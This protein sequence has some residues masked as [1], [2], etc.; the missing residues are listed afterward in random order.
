MSQEYDNLCR[1]Y[2]INICEAIEVYNYIRVFNENF[3]KDL[4]EVNNNITENSE[5]EYYP[6]IRSYNTHGHHSDLP[7]IQPQYYSIACKELNIKRG[8]GKSLDSYRPY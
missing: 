6:T 5:W 3:F 2:K 4:N 1:K 7:G 8:N